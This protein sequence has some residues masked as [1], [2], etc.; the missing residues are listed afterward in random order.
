[1]SSILQQARLQKR[2][3]PCFLWSPPITDTLSKFVLTAALLPSG[4]GLLSKG[5]ERTAAA[6]ALF[7]VL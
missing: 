3:V 4:R 7:S 5:E 2:P 6:A 1:M